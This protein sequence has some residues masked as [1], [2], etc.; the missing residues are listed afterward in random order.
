MCCYSCSS[1]WMCW[2][3]FHVTTASLIVAWINVLAGIYGFVSVI[4][5]LSY[6]L[7]IFDIINTISG[8][9]LLCGSVPIIVGEMRGKRTSKMYRPFLIITVISLAF[10]ALAV[11]IATVLL[12]TIERRIYAFDFYYLWSYTF[13]LIVSIWLYSIVYRAYKFVQQ[14]EEQKNGGQYGPNVKQ[15]Q[16]NANA[17]AK[18]I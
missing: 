7:Y 9:L 14:N 16:Q 2:C 4:N 12:F 18:V 6:N 3:G 11:I 13:P 5:L 17:T 15:Y 10:I 8:I 1:K